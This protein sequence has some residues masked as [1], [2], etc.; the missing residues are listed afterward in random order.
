MN[1]SRK[2][3]QGKE[4]GHKGGKGRGK[5]GKGKEKTCI[6]RGWNHV[7]N[8]L[9]VTDSTV[10]WTPW[11]P[12][13]WSGSNESEVFGLVGW[14]MIKGINFFFS[15]NTPQL[16]P[17]CDWIKD[18]FSLLMVISYFIW[19]NNLNYSLSRQKDKAITIKGCHKQYCPWK[20]KGQASG[21][22]PFLPIHFTPYLMLM[23]GSFQG[24]CSMKSSLTYWS[25]SVLLYISVEFIFLVLMHHLCWI[26][27][28]LLCILFIHLALVRNYSLELRSFWDL[29]L[30]F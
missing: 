18:S 23:Y 26:L 9:M 28:F 27:K 3:V 15:H 14:C 4:E 20:T 11:L 7:Y 6:L 17:V 8:L 29:K 13:W 16:L 24:P 21:H 25:W 12:R 5:E 10:T 2:R 30:V 22:T 19:K 1:N